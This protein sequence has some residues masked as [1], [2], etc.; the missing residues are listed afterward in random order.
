MLAWDL[1]AFIVSLLLIGYHLPAF[2]ASLL[3]IGCSLPVTHMLSA[4]DD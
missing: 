1:P 2:I 3:L 4:H